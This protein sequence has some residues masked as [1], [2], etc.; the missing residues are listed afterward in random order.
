MCLEIGFFLKI[1]KR[2]TAPL[3]ISNSENRAI[4]FHLTMQWFTSQSKYEE[5][6]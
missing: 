3:S 4:S 2:L 5:H 1:L 6:G